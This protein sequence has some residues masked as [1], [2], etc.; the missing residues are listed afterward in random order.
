MVRITK[1]QQ[2][3]QEARAKSFWRKPPA[4]SAKQIEQAERTAAKSITD[5]ALSH[6]QTTR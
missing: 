5:R 4:K 1:R 3:E 6:R 2:A